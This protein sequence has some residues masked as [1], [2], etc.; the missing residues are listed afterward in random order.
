MLLSVVIPF[1]HVE[2]YIA[3]C[4]DRAAMLEDCEILLV[5]DCGSDAS[6]QIA[7]AYCE[8]YANMRVIRREKNGGLSAARNTGL[9]EAKGEYVYFLDSDDL[10]EPDALM[11]LVRGAKAQ[12][13]DVA[14]ARFVFFDD[15]TG[16]V[17]PGPAIPETDAMTGGALFASQCR[18]GLYE[19]M[20]WQ[21][22]Y[23]RAFLRENGLIMA[24]GLLFEDEL[25][26]AP[27]LMKARRAAAF[28]MEIL[29][30]RQRAGSIMGSFAKSSRWCSSYLEVCRRLS[31]L[32]DTLEKGEAK[33]ALKKRVGQ[34]ALSTAK[35]IPAYR[36]PPEIAREA[37]DFV[38]K[39][40]KELS[41]YALACG[42][43]K[44]A[45]QGA[46]LR[47]SVK[48]FLLAYQNR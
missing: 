19:P 10:P 21:C 35:N 38:R 46:L 26:Q 7:A 33:Q 29:R 30:Y 20:V 40:Q 43:A 2:K 27:C 31:A 36:L 25:F 37:T 13:L 11:A 12:Q 3:D 23:R 45:A 15:E 44:V 42:D 22:V 1:Y 24:E 39:N 4:L 5:D 32:A 28:E 16:E 8:R 47:L 18:A 17:T 48:G 41:G 34:I 6:A 9:A 14:K